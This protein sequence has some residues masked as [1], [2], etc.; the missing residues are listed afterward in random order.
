MSDVM[1]EH[2]RLV[3]AQYC[4]AIPYWLYGV[5][6]GRPVEL[7]GGLIS[8]S[9]PEVADSGWGT[10]GW[11]RLFS[12]PVMPDWPSEQKPSR[13]PMSPMPGTEQMP[14]PAGSVAESVLAGMAP[15]HPRAGAPA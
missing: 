7:A 12:A 4:P 9:T 6:I 14:P 10:P 15:A 3:A 8:E 1:S 11:H 5:A 13:P 2:C